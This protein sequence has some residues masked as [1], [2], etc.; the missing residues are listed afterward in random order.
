MKE[1]NNLPLGELMMRTLRW[2]AIGLFATLTAFISFPS[3]SAALDCSYNNKFIP[4][5]PVGGVGCVASGSLKSAGTVE[6][7][8][9]SPMEA[10]KGVALKLRSAGSSPGSLVIDPNGSL[11]SGVSFPELSDLVKID[12]D[13]GIRSNGHFQLSAPEDILTLRAAAGSIQL[14]GTGATGST[15]IEADSVKL[16]SAKGDIILDGVFISAEYVLEMNAPKGD[17]RISNSIIVVNDGTG[18]CRLY[19][20]GVVSTNNNNVFACVPNP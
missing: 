17:I 18:P 13:T 5:L 7:L 19:A 10:K 2:Q 11:V 9:S 14:L 4:P 15:I 1:P 16:E 6:I 20:G 3:L 8:A 12:A